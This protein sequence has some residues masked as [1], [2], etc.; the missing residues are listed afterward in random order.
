MSSKKTTQSCCPLAECPAG[1]DHRLFVSTGHPDRHRSSDP[2]LRF[3][4]RRSIG[5]LR[6]LFTATSATCVTGLVVVDTATH[7]T[8]FGK[9]VIISLIQIGGLGLV[10]ITSFFY[11]FMRRRSQP[12]RPWSS[13]RS[14]RPTSALPM[15]CRLVRK[16]IMIT[17]SIETGRRHPALLAV[18]S[19]VRLGQR[20]RQRLFP[21]GFVLL[22]CRL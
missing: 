10:T 14:R 22:Q 7:W 18:H 8:M 1:P 11:S 17:F 13:L 21:V 9:M 16:I 6:A 19:R 4:R 15:C 2:A 3:E 20:H 12:A 5:F